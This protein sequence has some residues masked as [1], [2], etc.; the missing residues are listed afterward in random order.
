M[1][2]ENKVAVPA[3]YVLVFRAWY[4]DKDGNRVYAKDHGKRGWP[5]LIR[6]GK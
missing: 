4:T 6:K 1:A 5:L 2:T 3:G